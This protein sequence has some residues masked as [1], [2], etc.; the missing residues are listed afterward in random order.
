MRTAL[1]LL[2]LSAVTALAFGAFIH[3]GNP[4]QENEL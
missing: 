2:V 4:G 1:I 3:A